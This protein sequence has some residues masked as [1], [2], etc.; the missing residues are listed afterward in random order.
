M[1]A[2]PPRNSGDSEL[3]PSRDQEQGEFNTPALAYGVGLGI[4]ASSVAFAITQ[5]PIWIGIGIPFGAAL[6]IAIGEVL[7]GKRQ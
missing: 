2:G 7:E 5:N 3:E 6:G 1:T 4:L